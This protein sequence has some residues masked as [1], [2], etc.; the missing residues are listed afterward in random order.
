M[1]VWSLG[2]SNAIWAA[3]E[4]ERM[5][6]T[7]SKVRSFGIGFLIG[8]A[9]ELCILT[10]TSSEVVTTGRS[11][12]VRTASIWRVLAAAS[13]QVWS[14]SRIDVIWAASVGRLQTATFPIPS[15]G[16][17]FSIGT[18]S[19]WFLV[20]CRTSLSV[21]SSGSGNVICT[22]SISRLGTSDFLGFLRNLFSRLF[23]LLWFRNSRTSLLIR[24][25]GFRNAIGTTAMLTDDTASHRSRLHWASFKV[26]ALRRGNLIRATSKQRLGTIRFGT[27]TVLGSL[28]R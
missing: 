27:S 6:R 3:S 4:L 9:A 23:W 28:R 19:E 10:T 14:P 11:R 15:M 21:W 7:S 2:G 5:A 26:V 22:T 8:T 25:L 12:V 18:A 17:C 24:S 13:F 20:T 1:V 16:R